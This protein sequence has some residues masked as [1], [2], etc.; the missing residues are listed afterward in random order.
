M[1]HG[2]NSLDGYL[3]ETFPADSALRLALRQRGEPVRL[4]LTRTDAQLSDEFHLVVTDDTLTLTR[5]GDGHTQTLPVTPNN[6]PE[7]LS[8]VLSHHF[9]LPTFLWL[10]YRKER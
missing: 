5:C 3:W 7:T 6:S 1:V 2:F 4:F 9:G 10:P 8:A